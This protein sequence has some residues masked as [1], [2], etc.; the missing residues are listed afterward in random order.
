MADA[1]V[2]VAHAAATPNT[3]VSK[4]QIQ[5]DANNN[6]DVNSIEP[7]KQTEQAVQVEPPKPMDVGQ[8]FYDRKF[9]I[10]EFFSFTTELHSKA[11]VSHV[12]GLPLHARVSGATFCNPFF[13][14]TT[15]TKPHPV[16]KPLST[17]AIIV[18]LAFCQFSASVPTSSLTPTPTT[19]TTTTTSIPMTKGLTFFFFHLSR[20]QSTFQ[21][22]STRLDLF[23]FRSVQLCFFNPLL[24]FILSSSLLFCFVLIIKQPTK[25]PSKR[26]L[27]A[28][29]PVLLRHVLDSTRQRW[30][31][32]RGWAGSFFWLFSGWLLVRSSH[33]WVICGPICSP[34]L[35]TLSSL[36]RRT[37]QSHFFHPLVLSV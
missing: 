31:P 11:H 21:N 29:P 9:S 27:S 10:D 23:T 14:F 34:I 25:R 35:S 17:W 12:C 1:K 2:T 18:N 36:F 7:Q 32:S 8:L 16:S 30:L 24:M 15:L 3:M 28:L 20:N 33:P 6:P 13:N 19:T 26:F 22:L 4:P 37:N 5:L